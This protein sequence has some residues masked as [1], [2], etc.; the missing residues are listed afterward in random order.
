MTV[1][2]TSD[3]HFG[4]GGALGLFRRPFDSVAAMDAALVANWNVTVAPDD[5]VWHLGD[6]AVG[7][8][9]AAVA[10]I[11]ARLNGTKHLL[12][13]NADPP[14]VRA[15]PQWASVADLAETVV[16]GRRLVLCHY[17]LRAWK[18]EG[19]GAWQLHGHSHGRLAPLA[20]QRDVGV[21]AWDFRPVALPALTARRSRA[22]GRG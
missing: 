2:F 19:R 3:T 21:D 11:L 13:G 9:A 15:L 5:T 1:W 6:V 12:A 8:T 16:D 18:D 10:A 7:R 14:A 20:R 17:P 22:A 4:H